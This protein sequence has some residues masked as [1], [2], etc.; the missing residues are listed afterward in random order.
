MQRLL[1]TGSLLAASLAGASSQATAPPFLK[2]DY[3]PGR[4]DVLQQDLYLSK[5]LTAKII[6]R[7]GTPVV[8]ADGNTSDVP[9]HV[10]PDGAAVF[11]DIKTGGWVYVSNSEADNYNGGV[12]AVHFD[13]DGNV[14]DY[15]MLLTG[16]NR[17]CNGGKTDWEAW[18]SCEGTR[19]FVLL[20][21]SLPYLSITLYVILLQRILTPKASVGRSTPLESDNPSQLRLGARVASGRPLLMT[22]ETPP[23]SMPL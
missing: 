17:N 13:A 7:A 10:L 19:C 4:L 11:E 12:G 14:V 15:K 21:Y 3:E 22:Q 9:F 23:D 18:I 6:A 2:V 1:K 8:Y 5:G 16:T 20:L